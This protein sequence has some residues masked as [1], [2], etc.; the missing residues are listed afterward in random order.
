[1]SSMPIAQTDAKPV[2]V[3]FFDVRDTLGEVDRPGHLVLYKPSTEKLLEAMKNVV[4]MRIGIITNLPEGVTAETGRKM[5]EEAGITPYLDENGLI[6]NHEAGASK[7]SAKI[8]QFAAQ[9]VAV[10]IDQCMYVSENL[11]EVIGAQAAGMKTLLKPC[12][13]GR[14]F[15]NAPLPAKS[16][17]EI[18]SGRVFELIFEEEHLL[19]KRIVGCAIKI[20]Q[21]IEANQTPLPSASLNMLVYLARYFIDPFHHRKEEEILFPLALARGMSPEKISAIVDEHDQGRAYFAA[22]ATALKR[23]SRGDERAL[24]DFKIC[25][26]GF[27]ELY[28][29]HGKYEDDHLFPEIGKLL[30]DSD[31]SLLINLVQQRGPTDL[32][33]YLGLIQ[34]MERELKITPA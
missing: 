3:V 20:V 34:D 2:K 9:K 32:T 6:I 1:M 29:A 10:P 19:G 24:Y 17:S 5:L 7:P 26:T 33:P 15:L 4:G 22:M 16:A 14:E 30:T 27:I 23:F 31:D 13:P 11:I 18:F 21:A 25:T 8:Y 12:P 28:K